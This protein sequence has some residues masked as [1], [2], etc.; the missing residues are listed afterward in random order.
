MKKSRKSFSSKFKTK[1]KKLRDRIH[2]TRL[3]EKIRHQSRKQVA[4][5]M[6]P[7]TTFIEAE[8]G[9]NL[10]QY[11]QPLLKKNVSI[12]NAKQIFDLDFD[13]GDYSIEYS[14]EGN[15]LLMSSSLGHVSLMDW[16]KKE[17]LFEVQLRDRVRQ[18][19]FMH[20]RFFALA[21]SNNC[22]I[23]D[24]EG[25]EVHDLVNMPE[26][27]HIEYLPWHYLLA[28]VSAYGMYLFT[29]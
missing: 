19:K 13:F 1:D 2:K 6:A 10:L 24:F 8:E 17:L 25:L 27:L 9:E 28:S 26:P 5:Y 29:T 12:N 4:K 11:R 3:A 15:S 20:E 21:Q 18:A 22:F 16:K 14:R 23:Y 7:V